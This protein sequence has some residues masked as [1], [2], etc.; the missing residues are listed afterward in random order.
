[1]VPVAMVTIQRL[2]QTPDT[3]LQAGR[4]NAMQLHSNVVAGKSYAERCRNDDS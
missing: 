2:I 4:I 1:M 3:I